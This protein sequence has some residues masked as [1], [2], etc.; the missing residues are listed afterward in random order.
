MKN[1]PEI[2]GLKKNS[3]G[4]DSVGVNLNL[5]VCFI[6]NVSVKRK[7]LKEII[8]HEEEIIKPATSHKITLEIR[9][10]RFIVVV[11]QHIA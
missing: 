9:L 3:L 4:L 6:M 5:I 2:P 7:A 10:L 8:I 1:N 11:K